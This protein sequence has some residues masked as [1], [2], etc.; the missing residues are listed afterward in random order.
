MNENYQAWNQA[1]AIGIADL[2]ANGWDKAND[3]DKNYVSYN[4]NIYPPKEVYRRAAKIMQQ[5]DL[6]I[7]IKNLGD[8]KP[9]NEFLQQYGYEIG[10]H[11]L[12]VR[13]S[14]Q[15]RVFL[16][17]LQEK[18]QSLP[19]QRK[20][21][22]N[23]KI[24]TS[25]YAWISDPEAKI[26]DLDAHYE[27]IRRKSNG[28]QVY[29]E[30][31]FEDEKMPYDI[32]QLMK[33][34]THDVLEKID[35]NGTPAI[36]FTQSYDIYSTD[37]PQD[38]LN[39]LNEVDDLIGRELRKIMAKTTSTQHPEIERNQIL[40]GPPG[41]GK[42]YTTIDE[43]LKIVDPIEY[44]KIMVSGKSDG[45]IRDA[46]TDRFR[47]L[48][49]KD[50]DNPG[51]GKIVFT[52]FHQS[53][54]YEDFI[55]G[56]K[57][58]KDEGEKEV[59]YEIEDGLFKRLCDLAGRKHSAI[60]F[61]QAYAKFTM[62][63]REKGSLELQTISRKVKFDIEIN[64]NHTAVAIPKSKKSRMSVTKDMIREYI[65]T[66]EIRD[67][68]SYV[69]AIGKYIQDTYK[70]EVAEVDNTQNRYVIIIDEINRGNVSAIF[71]ELITLIE[72]SKRKGSKEELEVTLPYSKKPFSVPD[73]V[74]LVG[75]MNTADR[76]VEALDT[77]L[78]RRFS[79]SE[80]MPR[81]EVLSSAV[82]GLNLQN[83]LRNIN[84]R[85]AKLIDNDHQIGHAYFI[86]LET[87]DQLITCFKNKILPLL[88]EYF[89]GETGKIG[90]VLG[91]SFLEKEH[92]SVEFAEF[93]EYSESERADLGAKV[94]YKISDP[95]NWLFE[96]I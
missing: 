11:E 15:F 31:H 70:V 56:I 89:Y 95:G 49:I 52:T 21:L 77:A 47:K 80:K 30:L 48:L 87:R 79:F 26:G 83:M 16:Q 41:T 57:P 39:A 76:S 62:E 88:G 2:E 58:K 96:T 4:G 43:A 44:H 69:T 86:D 27:V 85:L 36:Q 74:Y 68:D 40:Y 94:S 54:S 66:G 34:D 7:E 13:G 82:A 53:L 18:I 23:K 55:E 22:I 14:Q 84:S 29:L 78:R 59:Y 19:D 33:L 64:G 37:T 25:S 9:T 75:T 81:P 46:L 63:V 50:W 35:H 92:A 73:N 90:L 67:W 1:I 28:S 65:L 12:T 10:G 71:G 60:N 32:E 20:F 3:S 38:I 72:P 8:G 6:E 42:T 17:K 93:D 45:L 61:E 24:Q 51:E 5:D 91:S